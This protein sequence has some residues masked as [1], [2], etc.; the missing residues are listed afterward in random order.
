MIKPKAVKPGDVVGVIAPSDAVEKEDVEKGRAVL[1]SW[2]LKV[3]IG[4]HVYAKVGDFSAGTAAERM[5]DILTMINDPDVRV[6]WAAGGGYAATEILPVFNREVLVKLTEQPLLWVGYS[7]VCLIL[8]ALTSF[9]M[10]SVMGPNLAG[11]TEWDK[12]STAEMK[13][14][15]FGEACEGMA[16]DA[17]WRTGLAGTAEGR[18]VASNLETLI[19]SFGTRFDPLMYG[20]GNIILGLE[21]LDIDKSSLQRQLDTVL[22]HKRAGRITGIFVGRLVNIAEKSYPEWG[23]IVT[24]EGLITDRV[25]K[26]GDGKIPLA[27]CSDFGHPEWS[28][29]MFSK[30]L[31]YFA[32]RRFLPVPEGILARLTVEEKSVKLEYLEK[33][34]AE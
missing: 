20:S 28:Y 8:N 21:E 2:G 16:L 27:F 31:R 4:K 22:N 12:K 7:D 3:K 33:V 14:I 6:I 23:K 17:R 1:E 11:L 18:L 32:N 19:L 15:L 29:G 24:S 13:K 9:R 10:V 34:T 5:E 30:W 25:K 26:W